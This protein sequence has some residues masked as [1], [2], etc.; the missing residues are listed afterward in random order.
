MMTYIIPALCVIVLILIIVFFKST[1]LT[2]P[3]N[4]ALIIS[5]FRKSAGKPRV[6]IGGST[7]RI[8]FLERIDEI[9][10]DL[11]Q[12]DIKTSSSV[13]TSEY[14]NINV[15]A[16]AN[17][18]VASTPESVVRA[19]EN[20]LNKDA[21][22]I[23]YVAQQV[24]EGNMREII[25]QMKLSELIQKRDIFAQ[26]VQSSVQE[27]MSRMG[28]EVVNLTIQNFIDDNN[29]ITDLGIENIS[30]IRKDA[31]I[32]K[33]NAD[34]DV[35]IAQSQASDQANKAKVAAQASIAEQNKELAIRQAQFKIEEDQKKAAAD[36]A[37]KIQEEAER[38]S[39]EIA[40]AEAD[41]ARREK[42]IELREKEV[43]L[44]ER[45][46]EANVRKKAEAERYAAEQAAEAKKYEEA[47]AAEAK[48]IA[49]EEEAKGIEAI[50]IAEARA[51]E[52]KA[53]A[54][55]KL[56][57]AGKL[58]MLLSALPDIVKAASDPLNKVGSITMYGD[59]NS[60]RLVKDVMTTVNQ[61][62]EGVGLDI[63]G[64]I[65]QVMPKQKPDS[66]KE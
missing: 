9:A 66:A 35:A 8:P 5:G 4:K 10:L 65:S 16:V 49:M 13:P 53:E 2:A 47:Q 40:S 50:G 15:D 46:L 19:A 39:I 59:G 18:K 48:R 24:I 28:L 21:D 61:V 64:L 62:S 56:N 54:M 43:Q 25:G 63:P 3:P 7:I 36:A 27:E 34:R 6:V 33:A 20:F 23:G 55:A 42:E 37:Y 32:S 41:I 14:I 1:Y 22:H 11:I 29:V 60:T 31:A 58:E 44:K 30:Q 26:K 12:V 52:L 38:R 57:E 51:L 17:V 45:E